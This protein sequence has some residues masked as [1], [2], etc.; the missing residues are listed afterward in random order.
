[1]GKLSLFNFDDIKESS[2]KFNDDDNCTINY[3]N[4]EKKSLSKKDINIEKHFIKKWFKSNEDEEDFS[5][6]ML[7]LHK[8]LEMIMITFFSFEN[9][10][11]LNNIELILV[12]TFYSEFINYL[13]IKFQIQ[14]DNFHILYLVYNKKHKLY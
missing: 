12:D 9:F 6:K 14:L 8:I 2:P 13:N 5:D 4:I 11:N 7:K 3:K 1:M 10:E